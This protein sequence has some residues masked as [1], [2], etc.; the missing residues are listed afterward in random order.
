[1]RTSTSSTTLSYNVQDSIL[2]L[3]VHKVVIRHTSV[4]EVEVK[5]SVCGPKTVKKRA[6]LYD[7]IDMVY[8]LKKSTSKL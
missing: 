2:P 3:A 1:M 6:N 4:M 5:W 7:C 8:N